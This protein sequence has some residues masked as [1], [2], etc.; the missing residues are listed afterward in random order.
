MKFTDLI[1]PALLDEMI[2]AKYVKMQTHPRA[3]SKVIY[4]Y[5]DHAM[6][7]RV[8]NPVTTKCRGLIVDKITGD[9]L[10]RPFD[11]FFNYG[12]FNNE[13]NPGRNPASSPVHQTL[14]LSAEVQTTDKMDGSLG[15]LYP[16]MNGYAVASRGSF[17]SPQAVRA[18]FHWWKRYR[19]MKVPQ[20]WTLLFEIIYPDN[21][22]VVDYRDLDDLVLLGARN[23]ETGESIGPDDFLLKP[24]T[25]PRATVFEDRTLAEA[26]HRTPRP[27]AE[28]V[29]VRY[30]TGPDTGLRVKIK[31]DDYVALHRII[32]GMNARAVW[33]RMGAGESVADIQHGIPEEFWPW[34]ADI[35]N[36]LDA[37]CSNIM[38]GAYADYNRIKDVL[39]NGWTRKDFA[40][41]AVKSEY[42][43]LLFMLLDGRNIQPAIWKQIRPAG[44]ITMK[45]I[46][47]DEA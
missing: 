45:H 46:S 26:L 43:A 20:G 28:G 41:E 22:I 5:T 30:M 38:G 32:T 34:V 40:A 18:T 8:W 4:N 24:F 19:E 33:E 7:D 31:Q 2:E 44:E 9:V 6:W 39:V 11:K 3:L 27:N 47:E 16:M 14:D 35:G 15:I 21:R 10:A 37:Q 36:G 25:G 17:S 42:R 13:E 29:V 12:E 23:I 1:N